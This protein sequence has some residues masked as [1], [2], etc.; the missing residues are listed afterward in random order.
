MISKSLQR[1]TTFGAQRRGNRTGRQGMQAGRSQEKPAHSGNHQCNRRE[2]P[3]QGGSDQ[4]R[5]MAGARAGGFPGT[6]AALGWGSTPGRLPC[7]LTSFSCRPLTGNPP[8]LTA[9]GGMRRRPLTFAA[10][11]A[12][13]GPETSPGRFPSGPLLS[14]PVGTGSTSARSV[15]SPCLPW[16]AAKDSRTLGFGFT[17]ACGDQLP[18]DC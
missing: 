9:D 12:G 15:P 5:S 18:T 7:N 11:G 3:H 17:V 1:L 14:R 4:E 13:D 8:C 2:S 6:G 10:Q 16:E